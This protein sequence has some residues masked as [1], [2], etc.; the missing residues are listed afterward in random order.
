M[1]FLRS[2]VLRRFSILGRIGD[3]ALVGGMALR[4]AQR[5]GWISDEQVSRMGLA[6][7]SEKQPFGIGEMALG[8]AALLRLIRRKRSR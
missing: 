6:G 1:R 7:V 3:I 4:L 8:G 5:K 2:R